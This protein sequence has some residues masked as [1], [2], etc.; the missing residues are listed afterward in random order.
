MAELD[1]LERIKW[2]LSSRLDRITPKEF[3]KIKNEEKDMKVWLNIIPR[4]PNFSQT[5]HLTP[6]ISVFRPTI[7][8]VQE[9]K[10][11]SKKFTKI[12]DMEEMP[13]KEVKITFHRVEDKDGQVIVMVTI[14]FEKLPD[15]I[16]R[17]YIKAV[18]DGV[19]IKVNTDNLGDLLEITKILGDE[20][21][22]RKL[23]SIT[24]KLV[25][26]KNIMEI[27]NIMRDQKCE[28]SQEYV[29]VIRTMMKE[30][31]LG[32]KKD[33]DI[34]S[35]FLIRQLRYSRIKRKIMTSEQTDETLK[36]FLDKYCIN[37]SEL[38]VKLIRSW[39]TIIQ[40]TN[41]R[42]LDMVSQISVGNLRYESMIEFFDFLDENLEEEGLI[43]I[44]EQVKK[45][46]NEN[47]EPFVFE[48]SESEVTTIKLMKLE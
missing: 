35:N 38:K 4:H 6:T 42:I 2:T 26:V 27:H 48:T 7:S 36:T 12:Q 22:Q 44:K 19:Q 43:Q 33:M 29:R 20:N 37:L 10:D 45:G 13:E 8:T 47:L 39:V 1:E 41:S 31:Y 5:I 18:W 30:A 3:M 32:P 28:D 25:K 46:R 24:P 23:K 9:I 17:N 15:Y 34:L 40:P 11:L 14:K 16:I 21:A